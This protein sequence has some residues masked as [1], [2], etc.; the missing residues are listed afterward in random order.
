M[1]SFKL[2]VR[3]TRTRQSSN[4]KGLKDR[5][6]N[7]RDLS[8]QSKIG[9]K[10]EINIYQTCLIMKRSESTRLITKS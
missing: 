8:V 7:F 9:L 6:T 1:V 3:E 5:S 10:I 4:K 2:T